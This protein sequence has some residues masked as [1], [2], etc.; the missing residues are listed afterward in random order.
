MP[1]GRRL[2]CQIGDHDERVR[3]QRRPCRRPRRPRIHRGAD[4]AQARGARAVPRPA[5]T[6]RR[7]LGGAQLLAGPALAA[8]ARRRRRAG[9]GSSHPRCRD[10]HGHG[11][12]GA[13]RARRLHGRG[14]RPERGDA[15]CR[16][17]PLRRRLRPRRADRGTGRGAPVRGRELRRA[18]R[19]LPPALRRGPAR[20]GGRAGAR[21]ASGR[22]RGVAGVRSPAVAAGAHGVAAVHRGRAARAGAA[23]LARVG[24]ASVASSAPAS[25]ASTSA[26]RSSPS[27]ATGR[28]RGWRTCACGA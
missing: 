19:H 1:I 9:G 15:G 18:H 25:A 12:G 24:P 26:I 11:R 20:D 22:A 2:A 13:A 28:R 14:H 7:A 16:A 4:A 8:R 27:L 3:I 5:A 23:G 6:L 21:G 10:G 17:L